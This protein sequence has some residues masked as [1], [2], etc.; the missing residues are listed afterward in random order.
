VET[1]AGVG[2][3]TAFPHIAK[4]FRFGP[5][6]ETNCH[7]RAWSTPQMQPLDLARGEGYVE[8][9]CF[10]EAAVAAEEF[11]HWAAAKSVEDYLAKWAVSADWPVARNDKLMEYWRRAAGS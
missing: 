7:V 6:V 2:F 9:A 1:A 11:A 3:I 8:F 4:V 5:E 10:A